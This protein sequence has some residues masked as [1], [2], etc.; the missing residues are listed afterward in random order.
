VALLVAEDASPVFESVSFRLSS[1][2]SMCLS[3][4]LPRVFLTGV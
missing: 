4:C 1:G 2:L 3:C